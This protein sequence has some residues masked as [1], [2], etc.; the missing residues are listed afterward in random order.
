MLPREVAAVATVEEVMA[1]EVTVEVVTGAEGIFMVAAISAVMGA[2]ISVAAG[3]TSVVD[4]S[5]DRVLAA[6]VLSQFITPDR[7]PYGH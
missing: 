2:G 4:R 1:G 6:I 3:A 5:R 7:L